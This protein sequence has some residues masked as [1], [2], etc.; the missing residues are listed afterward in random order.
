LS[1]AASDDAE[2]PP[3]HPCHPACADHAASDYCR[4]SWQLHL[5]ELHERPETHW[6]K[7]DLGRFCALVPVVFHERCLAA[8]KLACP[9]TMAEQDF[10]RCV[11]VLDVLVR[12]FVTAEADALSALLRAEQVAEAPGPPPAVGALPPSAPQPSH[13][14]VLRALQYVENQLSDPKLTV[15]GVAQALGL[16][17]SYLSQL[18]SEHVGQ[19]LSRFIATQRVQRAQT[20]LA[21]T[22][23][24][25]KRIAV[26]TGH[27]NPNWFCHVFAALTGLTPGEYRRQSRG[28]TG[29]T[30]VQ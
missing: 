6:H 27:A 8:I 23:W 1:L 7:C 14:Q 18:F 28:Q 17:P 26:E 12:D 30:G 15:G 20:L 22:D 16:H 13:P 3:V 29:A 2:D 24:Q 9:A 4:E 19:R 21:T 10:E 5:A 25:V 11:E